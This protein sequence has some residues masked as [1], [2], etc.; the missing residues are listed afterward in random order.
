MK[1]PHEVKIPNSRDPHC[2]HDTI[3]WLAQRHRFPERDY[4]V[5]MHGGQAGYTSFWF[6]DAKLA[7]YTKLVRG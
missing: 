1:Y 6:K 3:E 5:D 4:E 2:G 7:V